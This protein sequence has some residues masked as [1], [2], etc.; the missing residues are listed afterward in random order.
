M[1]VVVVVVVVV[2]ANLMNDKTIW[3]IKTIAEIQM[4]NLVESGVEPGMEGG[5]KTR[6]GRNTGVVMLRSPG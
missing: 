2:V 4:G 5:L 6:N 3:E 1:Q